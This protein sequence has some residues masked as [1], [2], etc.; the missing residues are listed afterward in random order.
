MKKRRKELTL[1]SLRILLLVCLWL[2][3]NQYLWAKE[4]DISIG[5]FQLL[6][7]QYLKVKLV[8]AQVG[9]IKITTS[10]NKGVQT[11][12]FNAHQELILQTSQQG[13]VCSLANN[14]TN[15]R[16][17]WKVTNIELAALG[18]VTIDAAHRLTRQVPAQLLF[19]RKGMVIETVLATNIENAV[20]ITTASELAEIGNI[21]E[22]QAS[23]VFKAMA[24][25]VRSYLYH[26]RNRHHA[27]GYN[28]CDNTH[29]MLYLGE[30]ALANSPQT[31]TIRQAVL[32]TAGQ[33]MQYQGEIVPGYFNA[34][35]GGL[36][37]LPNEVWSANST[38]NTTQYQ[39]RRVHCGFCTQDHFYR[40]ERRLEVHQLWPVLQPALK[41][42]ANEASELIAHYNSMGI[43]Q[44]VEVRSANGRSI[45]PVTRFR[46]LIGQRL[47]WNIVLSNTYKISL[48]GS[49]V[50]F[51]GSGFGHNLG[52]CIAGASVQAR[53]GIDF[54]QILTYYFPSIEIAPVG[55][56]KDDQF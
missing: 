10:S 2:L 11:I 55:N 5:L 26:E 14:Q 46:Q 25:A 43:V 52:L 45:I 7:P 54:R 35:C 16:Q 32:A 6:K 24:I 53:Q 44:T 15:N 17:Q 13:L 42:S 51:K 21:D 18:S 36:T 40:W 8:D 33:V 38:T 41:F 9:E 12:P 34:C 19:S 28:L 31:D 1:T 4:G 56:I 37:A 20:A 48:R 22:A 29:C 47:G 50:I 23:E 39:F 49:E 3:P 27:N 30:D